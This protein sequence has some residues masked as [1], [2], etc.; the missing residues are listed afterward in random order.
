MDA[1][2]P[3]A[4]E[5]MK[6]R[7]DQRLVP[8][9]GI[10]ENENLEHSRILFPRSRRAHDAPESVFLSSRSGFGQYLRRSG[11]FAGLHR[12]ISVLETGTIIKDLLEVLRKGGLVERIREDD[13][14]PGYQ[15]PAAA[16]IWKAGDGIRPF[17]DPIRMPRLPEGGGRTNRF[18][19]QLYREAAQESIGL[20]AREHTAQVPPEEREKREKQF[21]EGRL[22]ILYCSATME[23]G[24]DIA[25]LNVVNLRNVPPTPANYAQR[26]GRAGRSGQPA[27]VFS[28]CSTFRSHD[29]YFFRRPLDMVSGSVTPPRIDL[30]NE[31]LLRSHIHSLWL[32]TA[33]YKFGPSLNSFLDCEGE[34]PSLALK[35]GVREDLFAVRHRDK[36][37]AGATRLLASIGQ[38]L[39]AAPWYNANWCKDM[40]DRIPQAFDQA[41]DRWRT[42]YRAALRQRAVQHG[43]EGDATRSADDRKRARIL[44]AE[45][46]QQRDLLIQAQNVMEADFYTYRYLASEG[47]LPGYNFPRLPLSAYVPARRRKTGRDEYI[48]RPRFIAIS[49]F[50]PRSLL[51]HEGARYRIEKVILP[52]RD[53]ADVLAMQSA[54]I[55]ASCGYLHEVGP[56]DT[57]NVCEMCG[58]ALSFS[59]R[60][61]FRME[62]VSTRRVDRINSDE[63]ERSRYGYDVHTVI[64]FAERSGQRMERRAE[65]RAEDGSVLARLAYGPAATLWRINRG[66]ARSA[67][68]KEPGFLLDIERGY[69]ARNP[70]DEQDEDSPMAQRTVRVLPYVEDHRNALLFE[71]LS[72]GA[73]EAE[74][75][76]PT[77]QAALKNSMLAVFQLEE[78]ELA[79]EPLPTTEDRRKILLYE[80]SEGGAG[81]L[82]RLVEDPDVLGQVARKA[83]EILHFDPETGHD[84]H[85]APRSKEDCEAACY[86]CLMTY[87]NQP[88]HRKLDRTVVKD[89]LMA[90]RTSRVE[91]APA[92]R[93][94]REHLEWLSNQCGSDLE[95]RWL[96]FIFDHDLALPTSAQTLV[97]DCQTRPDFFFP[98]NQTAVYVDGPPHDDPERAKRDT[99]QSAC[100]ENKGYTVIRFGHHDDWTALV[101]RYPSVFG[102]LP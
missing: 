28:Y 19:V 87:T 82:R 61:L 41:C 78:D 1:L 60:K 102:K 75:F 49:E 92:P 10:D 53:E 50:G 58:A 85:H 27:L 47:F 70:R 100:M 52:L 67:P 89:L 9:W 101:R 84:Q 80:S 6:Q 88:D 93:S 62:N 25:R 73:E 3:E 94:R 32:S 91:T 83:L 96:S 56:V 36:A 26:S 69:W 4:Q 37:E 81:V 59:E 18:F 72:L 57:I 7:S 46:E 5:R 55:C 35:P 48:S 74:R 15:L 38:E 39:S 24:V 54:K 77:L 98:D 33:Q 14:A 97:A 2:D 8:P 64:R 17:H 21:R 12:K 90:L 63:E 95:L 44:R 22:P 42:L 29:Q 86:D 71:P 66:W 65:V 20:E 99:A 30:A 45:A 16:L 23:L 13:E 34:K 79:A 51:Y 11:T 76:M 40:L 31:D 68:D 43:I